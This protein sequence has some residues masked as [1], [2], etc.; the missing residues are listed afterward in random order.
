MELFESNMV[1][2]LV[3]FTLFIVFLVVEEDEVLEAAKQGNEI[4]TPADIPVH[5]DFTATDKVKKITY[6]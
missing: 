4:P 5:L 3:D 1:I 6:I 2:W